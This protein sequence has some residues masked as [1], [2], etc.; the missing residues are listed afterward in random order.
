MISL[1]YLQYLSHLQVSHYYQRGVI[2]SAPLLHCTFSLMSAAFILCMFL[3][4]GGNRSTWGKLIQTWGETCNSPTERP[5]TSRS[6]TRD[7]LAIRQQR[8][9]LSHC[10]TEWSVKH[11]SMW[12]RR[13]EQWPPNQSTGTFKCPERGGGA[14]VCCCECVVVLNFQLQQIV[15]INVCLIQSI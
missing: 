10:A 1:L 4:N 12:T 8:K 5:A 6:R 9:L 7:F 2:P 3:G 11:R 14:Y 13:D 15:Q